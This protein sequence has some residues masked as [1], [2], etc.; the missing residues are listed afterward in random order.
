MGIVE[1]ANT[2]I[3]KPK[4]T[5]KRVQADFITDDIVDEII[6][7]DKTIDHDV[8][9]FA[10][11][12]Q[13]KSDIDLAYQLFHLVFDN[14]KYIEDP[15]GFQLIK[16]PSVTWKDR[17]AD[18]KSMSIFTASILKAL[19]IPYSYRF[20][21][22]SSIPKWTHVYVVM[23]SKYGRPI[24]KDGNGFII[25]PVWKIFNSEKKATHKKDYFM[26]GINGINSINGGIYR[27]EGTGDNKS[28]NTK[29]ILKLPDANKE[30]T[31]ADIDLAIAKQRLE[32]SKE[33]IEGLHGIGSFRANRIQQTINGLN[34]VQRLAS[35]GN[36]DGIDAIAAELLTINPNSTTGTFVKRVAKSVRNNTKALNPGSVVPAQKINLKSALNADPEFQ[37]IVAELA[38]Y[39]N[40]LKGNKQQLIAVHGIGSVQVAR[41]GA[42]IAGF[43]QAQRFATVGYVDGINAIADK[44]L[45][46]DP[47]S[48]SGKLLKKIA[49]KAK[50]VVKKVATAAKTVATKA[51]TAAKT[52]AKKASVVVKKVAT[53]ALKV[54]TAPQ[55]LLI[56]GFM[57]V[58][59]PK[60]APQFIYLFITDQKIIDKLPQTVKDKRAKQ[61]KFADF[62]VNAIGMKR[63]H[64]MGIFRNGIIKRY[65]ISPE[66][67]LQ[68]MFGGSMA[69][70]GIIED[71]MKIITEIINAI[72]KIFG[73]KAGAT[74][75]T[76]NMAPGDNDFAALLKSALPGLQ[77]A[78]Q[79]LG[80]KANTTATSLDDIVKQ[81]VQ[82]VVPQQQDFSTID[83]STAQQLGKE[84]KQQPS[85]VEPDE[86]VTSDTAIP[87]DGGRIKTS[88][89][90]C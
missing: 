43:E 5:V 18:C 15:A 33:I 46:A 90:F 3:S 31:D 50:A 62:I 6:L 14:V 19:N 59:L 71:A 51:V 88:G 22:Y 69:G 83:T 75:S 2:Y 9:L 42:E 39:T 34:H 41:V 53:T 84:I 66:K 12:L 45:S 17:F 27:I 24:D 7:M 48:V 81:A 63:E 52:V 70:I 21:S 47:D 77:T 1:L 78:M 25:D 29:T 64:L 56:K 55:R 26:N 68:E 49:A 67:K 72:K 65:K 36:A 87:M 8:F 85:S 73:S 20:A 76:T 30:W 82:D 89:S 4:G 74:P 80:D 60:A 23:H 40:K 10:Q 44:M 61:V 86:M 35:V 38:A 32:V 11:K 16:M 57:E 79:T 13:Y 28:I 58:T 37:K 54:I